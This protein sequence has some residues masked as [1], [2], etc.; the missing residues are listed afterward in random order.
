[1][2]VE[3]AEDCLNC[4]WTAEE[5]HYRHAIFLAISHNL[6]A[7][8]SL[9][10][11]RTG[12]T[13]QFARSLGHSNS[14]L[15]TLRVA[16]EKAQRAPESRWSGT[17]CHFE[18]SCVREGIHCARPPFILSTMSWAPALSLSLDQRLNQKTILLS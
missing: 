6:K 8:S 2:F 5:G 10:D 7:L 11:R 3:G 16:A 12:K 4:F 1:M 18:Q 17:I 9:L 15:G 13:S 14:F